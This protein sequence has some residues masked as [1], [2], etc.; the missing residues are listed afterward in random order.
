MGVSTN[1]TEEVGRIYMDAIRQHVPEFTP[2]AYLGDAA[3]AFANAAKHVFPTIVLRLMCYAHVY[4]A[5]LFVSLLSSSVFHFMS[6]QL[7]FRKK[8]PFFQKKVQLISRTFHTLT[9][10][11]LI[12]L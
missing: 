3:E 10:S 4:K 9:F 2:T 7:S 5:S 6:G 8:F 11:F 12:P 1:S